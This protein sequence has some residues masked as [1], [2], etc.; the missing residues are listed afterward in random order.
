MS[1]AYPLN[2]CEQIVRFEWREESHSLYIYVSA[3]SFAA[4]M[5]LVRKWALFL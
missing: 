4:N 1:Q 5:Q 3:K 2:M